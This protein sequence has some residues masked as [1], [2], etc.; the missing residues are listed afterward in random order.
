MAQVTGLIVFICLARVF[1]CVGCLGGIGIC[2]VLGFR[3]Y[4][5]S[6]LACRSNSGVFV[7]VSTGFGA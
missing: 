1:E 3:A 7:V 6:F 5:F 2:V 4:S